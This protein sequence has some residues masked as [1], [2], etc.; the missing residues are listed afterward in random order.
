MVAIL[1]AL[2]AGLAAFVSPCFLPIVPVLAAYLNGTGTKQTQESPVMA[3]VQFTQ[4]GVDGFAAKVVETEEKPDTKSSG[5]A[6]KGSLAFMAGFSSI[7]LAFWAIV[8]V[9]GLVAADAKP[10]LRVGGGIIL[11]FF[12]AAMMGIIKVPQKL[13]NIGPKIDMKAASPLHAFA[14]GGAFGAGASPCFGPLLGGVLGLILSAKTSMA[15]LGLLLVFCVGLG[16]PVVLTTLGFDKFL[17]HM[18]WTTRYGRH[19]QIIAGIIMMFFGVLM[20]SD[21]LG[22][23]SALIWNWS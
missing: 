13:Q 16:V 21:L 7:F 5:G 4:F 1:L 11:V 10:I 22:S 20:I 9:V 3:M 12:G 6:L 17:A 2:G 15:G 19:I 14:L 23:F 18:K 8:S